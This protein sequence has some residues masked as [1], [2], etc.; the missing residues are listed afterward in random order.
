[1]R[2]LGALQSWLRA[3]A[4]VALATLAIGCTPGSRG[5]FGGGAV[6]YVTVTPATLDVRV[7]PGGDVAV[8]LAVLCYS[9]EN[10]PKGYLVNLQWLPP[11][12]DESQKRVRTVGA[13]TATLTSGRAVSCIQP[14]SNNN[15]VF[16]G[17]GR[18][19]FQATAS[20]PVG[21][22]FRFDLEASGGGGGVDDTDIANITVTVVAPSGM[23]P[24]TVGTFGSGRVS[25]A[26]A[27][28]NCPS[29]CAATFGA[30][31]TVTLTAT[32]E[33]GASFLAWNGACSGS[34]TTT[35]VVLDTAKSCSATFSLAPGAD[36]VPLTVAVEGQGT[37]T[38][39][40]V[41]IACPGACTTNIARSTPARTISLT[42]TPAAGQ[43][44]FA[45]HGD[46]DCSDGVLTMSAARSCTA[47]FMPVLAPYPDGLGWT[48]LGAP[49]TL[50]S[51]VDP[52]PSLARDGNH[53]V[54]A[55]V[56]A[57]AGDV[58][59]L[60]VKRL[61]G[62]SFVTLGGGA[63]NAGSI[64]AASEPSLVT[65]NSGQPFVAWI[66]GNGIQQNVFVARF[67]GTAWESVGPLGTP[68]NYV[69]GS[70]ASR[71]ALALDAENRPLVAWLENG[72]VKLKRFDGTSWVAAAGG[73]GP[74]GATGDQLRMTT[75]L[76]GVPV[77]AWRQPVGGGAQ[78]KVVRGL[79]FEPLGTSINAPGTPMTFFDVKA[80]VGG[81]I[82]VT[83]EA[84]TPVTVRRQ[85]WDGS[86]W[87]TVA[88]PIVSNDPRP[89][90]SLVLVRGFGAEAVF[91]QADAANDSAF[92][93]MPGVTTPLGS[94]YARRLRSLSAVVPR[95]DSPIVAAT[96]SPTEGRHEL[97]VWRFYP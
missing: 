97:R 87:V 34:A 63:L 21:T 66:Q 78:L 7:V 17:A 90:Q 10:P 27:G 94:S 58:A 6:P 70:T 11:S 14:Q 30:G 51:E 54:V 23:Q 59:R 49:L 3:G 48:V 5:S 43:R 61:E 89:L 13:V 85:R 38:S 28:I 82:A 8:D 29:T 76:D 50:A 88:G 15:N 83:S 45:W 96:Q 65:T 64:T 60:Y 39:V 73:E 55:Y 86:A 41:G 4:I 57:L 68:L 81:A 72:A 22:V 77:L 53:P 37:V 26:P 9:D 74:V 42:P 46:A 52:A 31:Q 16:S 24:L 18:A 75:D 20:A 67:N 95:A 62:A 33:P 1:M 84:A 19:T 79:A 32:P 47:V 71:P 36:T 12:S 92:M 80:D 69:A 40:P 91:S 35:S 25:S 2:R 93:T 56:E 44:F